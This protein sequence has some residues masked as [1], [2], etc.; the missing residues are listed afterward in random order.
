MDVY[1]IEIQIKRRISNCYGAFFHYIQHRQL[2]SLKG[3]IHRSPYFWYH[4]M[5][6]WN[7]TDKFEIKLICCIWQERIY[8]KEIPDFGPHRVAVSALA[9]RVFLRKVE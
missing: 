5:L 2:F 6:Y 4:S 1:I 7:I 9:I 3:T 8:Q